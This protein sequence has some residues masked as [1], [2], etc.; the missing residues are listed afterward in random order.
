MLIVF[1]SNITIIISM[2]FFRLFHVEFS[3]LQKPP[4][5]VKF[6]GYKLYFY[7]K[8]IIFSNVNIN[9]S[10]E[11]FELFHVFFQSSPGLVVCACS[12]VRAV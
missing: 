7:I 1:F 2:E 6:L 4:E 12:S 11:F 8:I 9:I 5:K 10:I 3:E